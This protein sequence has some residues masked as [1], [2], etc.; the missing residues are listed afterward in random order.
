MSDK[1]YNLQLINNYKMLPS[2]GF[3]L[4][5]KT[6][7][8]CRAETEYIKNVQHLKKLAA[9]DYISFIHQLKS[10]RT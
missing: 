9:I 10:I 6:S 8:L 3:G 4:I 5:D 7:F 2:F 1:T